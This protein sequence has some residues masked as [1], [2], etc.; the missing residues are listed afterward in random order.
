MSF[1]AD[2]NSQFEVAKSH[3]LLNVEISSL[4][5]TF[6]RLLST[7]TSASFTSS[8][9]SSSALVSLNDTRGEGRGTGSKNRD[10]Q[11]SDV[12]GV[13]CYYCHEPSHTTRTCQHLQN[14]TRNSSS[15]NV[16]ITPI[17]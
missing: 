17:F 1:L 6:N 11:N 5:E 7:N 8:I 16:D 14:R 2:L 13:I 10:T 9:I 12:G 15:A 4:Q 3:I